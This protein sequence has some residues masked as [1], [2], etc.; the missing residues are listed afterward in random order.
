MFDV[1]INTIRWSN[2]ISG[3]T[4]SPGQTL[5]ILPVSGVRHTVKAK[6]TLQSIAKTY[7]GDIDEIIKYND[8]TEDSILSVGDII[9]VP[10]G[11]ILAQ[12]SSSS[13][14]A[15]RS[16]SGS[17]S[18]ASV[19]GGYYIRPTSGVKTQGIHGYNAVDIAPPAGTSIV[20]SAS[21]K[22]IISRNGGWNGGYGSYV[23][24]EHGNGTQ[25]LYAHMS[26]TAISQ[27]A[28]VDQGDL[29][30]YVGATGKATGAHLH[31]EIRGA[32]NPF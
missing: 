32:K 14:S 29:I 9:I 8:V 31:F 27:G 10:N 15:V 26:T 20:A 4:I 17:A 16:S 22:V 19:S 18:Q 24:I 13:I 11:A 6:D 21:G 25:T 1:S 28:F 30:G 23:V 2:D 12:P 5:V 3:S 7:K